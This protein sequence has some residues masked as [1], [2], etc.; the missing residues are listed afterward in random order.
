M[1]Q[2]SYNEDDVNASSFI[3]QIITKI[4]IKQQFKKWTSCGYF[5]ILELQDNISMAYVAETSFFSH[6][7][8]GHDRHGSLSNHISFNMFKAFLNK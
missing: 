4:V 1:Q 8:I 2:N 5:I 6:V 7:A 3:D